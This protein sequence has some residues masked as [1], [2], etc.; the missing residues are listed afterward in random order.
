MVVPPQSI[1]G[2]T[3][4][5]ISQSTGKVNFSHKFQNTFEIALAELCS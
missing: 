4:S 5:V 2:F 1:A 3:K